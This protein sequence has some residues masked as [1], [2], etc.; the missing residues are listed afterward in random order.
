MN[1]KPKPEAENG[2]CV[3]KSKLDLEIEY[4]NFK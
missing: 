4:M 2:F 1:V 3:S